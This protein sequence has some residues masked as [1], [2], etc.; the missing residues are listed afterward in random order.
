[1]KSGIYR[2]FNIKNGKMYIGSSYRIDFRLQCHLSLLK[3][4][5]HHSERLQND[6]NEYG[7]NYFK[8]EVLE[9][10]D[11]NILLEREQFYLD[12]L[13]KATDYYNKK[14]NFFIINGY[15]ICPLSKKGFSNYHSRESI[16][17]QLRTKGFGE[18]YQIDNEG[19]V[20][21]SFEIKTECPDNRNNVILS[22]RTGNCLRNR[23][24]G[25]IDSND[26][27]EGF[28]PKEL[29]VWNKDVKGLTNEKN[30][31]KIFV[32]NLYGEFVCN[33]D[34]VSQCADYFNT[35]LGNISRKLNKYPKKI[36]IDSL[37]SKYLMFND[38]NNKYISDINL[39]WKNIFT[40]ISQNIDKLEVFDC[41]DNFLGYSN[42][43]DLSKLLD[44]TLSS[45]YCSI[46]K[47][48]NIKSL[49]IKRIVMI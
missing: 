29:T 20:L 22:I 30:R 6:W 33:F 18:I 12:N 28:K 7:E 19:N 39:Y 40:K 17:K 13:L 21:N 38:E 4:N 41:F 35:D 2:I 47:K 1:M 10:C 8:T 15:N 9:Y 11:K 25:Y 48:R 36:L 23:N 34:S 31:K 46:S 14:D 5:N 26:Y 42:E 37:S 49:S 24:Y 45:I 27:F 43:I 16:I 32:F 44:V 3:N